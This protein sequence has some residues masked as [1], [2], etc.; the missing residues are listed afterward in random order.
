MQSF[1]LVSGK[2]RK[3]MIYYHIYLACFATLSEL[4]TSGTLLVT[5]CV[6]APV[7]YVLTHKQM[8]VEWHNLVDRSKLT[9]RKP[10]YL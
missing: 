5:S 2:N 10:Q 4:G 8:V 1:F 9:V 6:K 3:E 7:R